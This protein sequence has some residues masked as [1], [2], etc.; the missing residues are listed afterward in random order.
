MTRLKAEID[1][2][3]SQA[4]KP[5]FSNDDKAK[6]FKALSADESIALQRDL[7]HVNGMVANM[8]TIN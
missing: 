1:K 6:D 3:K 8:N 2:L 7:E 5:N 4:V